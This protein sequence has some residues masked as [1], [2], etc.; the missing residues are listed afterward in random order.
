MNTKAKVFR[1][2]SCAELRNFITERK[3]EERLNNEKE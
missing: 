2:K 1:R 3:L